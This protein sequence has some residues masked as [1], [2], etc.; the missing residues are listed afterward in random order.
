MCLETG[1]S[2]FYRM[3]VIVLKASFRELDARITDCGDYK[4]VGRDNFRDDM[5]LALNSQINYKGFQIFNIYHETLNDHVQKFDPS[6]QIPF[7]ELK[8]LMRN[9]DKEEIL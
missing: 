5:I 7:Y 4:N 6:N 1:F 3:T 9:Y 2:D 8:S